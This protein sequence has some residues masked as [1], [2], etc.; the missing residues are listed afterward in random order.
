MKLDIIQ[1]AD[2][3]ESKQL[4]NQVLSSKNRYA[5]DDRVK[6]LNQDFGELYS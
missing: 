1:E 6:I 2:D 4:D 3:E 5:D